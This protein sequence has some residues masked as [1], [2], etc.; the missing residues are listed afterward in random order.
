[1]FLA[2]DP[3]RVP[4]GPLDDFWYTPIGQLIGGAAAVSVSSAMSLSA[5]YACVR[6][7]SE[8][9]AQLPLILYRRKA[10]GSKER[11]TNHPL[12]NLFRYRPNDWQTSYEF[13]EMMQAHLELRGNA[14]AYIDASPTTG[15]IR[16]L[17]PLHPDRVKLELLP[18]G[19]FRYR[20]RPQAGGERILNRGEVFHVRGLSSDGFVGL[21]TIEMQ[22]EAIGAGLAARDYGAKYFQ[23][24]A[25]VGAWIEMPGGFQDEEAR[26]KFRDSWQESQTGSNRWKTPV[27]ERGMKLNNLGISAED[28]KFIDA[29][30]HSDADMARMFR[31][32]PHKIGILERATFSNIEQQSLEFVTDTMQPKLVR[33]EQAIGRDLLPDGGE[34]FVEFLLDGLLRGDSTARANYYSSGITN[35]WLTRNEARMKENLERI[36]GL[37][38]PLA[39]LNM[40]P[41]GSQ[42]APPKPKAPQQPD[43]SAMRIARAAAERVLRKEAAAGDSIDWLAHAPFVAEVLGVSSRAAHGYAGTRARGDVFTADQL[44]AWAL[45]QE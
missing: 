3:N 28:S 37:D 4:R 20:F 45:Q 12:Y 31:V 26:A 11:A 30:K 2:A 44:A 16:A 21:S 5:V 34:L 27:L 9:V 17:I 42:Q 38:E 13:V 1:M 24:N 22:R 36:D 8:S 35:G 10:D 7:I 29:M 23:N 18:N 32:P 14:Y 33:W 6:V 15:A 43:Q 39:P 19:D 25:S 41:A 40:A